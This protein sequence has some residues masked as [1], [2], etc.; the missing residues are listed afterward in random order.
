MCFNLIA[1][2]KIISNFDHGCK[3]TGKFLIN[4]LKPNFSEESWVKSAFKI[5]SIITLGTFS[6][7]FIPLSFGL[8]TAIPPFLLY[9]GNKS[10]TVLPNSV[11]PLALPPIGIMNSGN[12]CYFN[13]AVQLIMNTPAYLKAAKEIGEKNSFYKALI[14]DYQKLQENYQKHHTNHTGLPTGEGSSYRK[15]RTDLADRNRNLIKN[16]VLEFPP[17]LPGNPNHVINCFFKDMETYQ[18]SSPLLHKRIDLENLESYEVDGPELYAYDDGETSLEEGIEKQYLTYTKFYEIPKYFLFFQCGLNP[19]GNIHKFTH[20]TLS[21]KLF[22][23]ISKSPHK[24][25]Y[26]STYFSARFGN[27]SSGHFM[28]YLKVNQVWYKV[29]DN[30]I[31]PMQEKRVLKDLSKMGVGILHYEAT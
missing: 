28:C 26:H 25:S 1:N 4:N 11:D 21:Q 18:I 22:D 9:R 12:D 31:H 8:S 5:A 15:F 19:T 14:E 23:G 24:N 13:I 6:I 17:G 20:F 7:A 27:L 30:Y 3:L 10:I 16:Q 2:N 29:D